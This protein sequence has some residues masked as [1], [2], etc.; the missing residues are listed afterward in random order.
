MS[1]SVTLP[2]LVRDFNI[3]PCLQGL[4]V[5]TAIVDST[6]ETASSTTAAISIAPAAAVPTPITANAAFNTPDSTTAVISIAPASAVPTPITANAAFN[7]PDSTTAVISIAPASAVPTP[8]TA[9]AAF[10]TTDSTTAPRTNITATTAVVTHS[11]AASIT[12]T[13]LSLTLHSLITDASKPITVTTLTTGQFSLSCFADMFG[14]CPR[15]SQ[16]IHEATGTSV[17]GPT[18]SPPAP[19]LTPDTSGQPGGDDQFLSRAELYQHLATAIFPVCSPFCKI[20]AYSLQQETCIVYKQ[21]NEKKKKKKTA[22]S[23]QNKL[24][25]RQN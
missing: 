19:I 23:T 2:N 6:A 21:T 25:H 15:H 17:P 20:V 22:K 7:T 1:I 8:I 16:G 14:L 9:N 4:A 18:A 11:T 24:F 3:H 13:G 10:N 12:S 5:H